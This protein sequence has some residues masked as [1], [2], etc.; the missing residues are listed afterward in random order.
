MHPTRA[1]AMQARAAEQ[2]AQAVVTIQERMAT[3]A[4]LARIEA[5]LDRLLAIID[6]APLAPAP[7]PPKG[8]NA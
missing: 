1:A 5:K 6:V 3:A 7:P 8:R 2:S 4:D